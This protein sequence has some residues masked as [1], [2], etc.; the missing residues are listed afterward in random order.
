MER[1]RPKLDVGRETD[2]TNRGSIWDLDMMLMTVRTD[3]YTDHPP[4]CGAICGFRL[5]HDI[6]TESE[7]EK[8]I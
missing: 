3:S 1:F 2:I 8:E 7:H 5:A 6:N 4:W